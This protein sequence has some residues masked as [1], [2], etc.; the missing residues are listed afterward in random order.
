M[1]HIRLGEHRA[2]DPMVDDL[3]RTFVG[4]RYGMSDAE[5]YEA[6]RGCWRLGPG[7]QDERFAIFSYD[8]VVRQA[9]EIS[10]VE[11]A[12][13]RSMRSII[14]G[15]VLAKGN[16]IYDTY[17]NQPAPESL[18]RNP[19]SYLPDKPPAEDVLNAR[20]S[21]VTESRAVEIIAM[22][23][24][25]G[26]YAVDGWIVEDVSA[27]GLGWDITATKGPRVRH[28]EV[29][30]VSGPIPKVLITQAELQA[31]GHDLDWVLSVVT[32]ALT[33]PTAR[34]YHPGDIR[35]FA[36]PLAYEADLRGA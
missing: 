36:V 22:S 27:L 8:G 4:Y 20:F 11:A 18:G 9:L 29:K 32:N 6:N 21:G 14:Y 12:P 2:V 23:F 33:S 7:A 34:E 3:G 17:V 31:A 26:Q 13:K 30:G 1:L 25:C 35:K 15:R 19:I 5:M 24:V 16:P 28:I 10:S